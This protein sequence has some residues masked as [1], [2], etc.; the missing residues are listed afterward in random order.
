MLSK[1]L[2][3][4][5]LY[6]SNLKLYILFHQVDPDYDFNNNNLKE[7]QEKIKSLEISLNYEIGITSLFFFQNSNLNYSESLC[8]S[9]EALE[10]E[11]EFEFGN[12]VLQ[13]FN[14]PKY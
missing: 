13:L 11:S 7:L 4:F 14:K 9:I 10:L 5:Q 3:I 12:L 6:N 2:K 8:Q 1:A